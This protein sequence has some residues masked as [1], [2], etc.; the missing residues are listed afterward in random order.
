MGL[1]GPALGQ[2]DRDQPLQVSAASV[3]MDEKTGLTVYRGNV[4]LVQG[5]LRIEAD[6][7]E[8]RM[9]GQQLETVTAIGRPV[10]VRALLDN[11]K[12]ELKASAERLVYHANAR[13]LELSGNVSLN[14][15]GDQ[16]SAQTLRY[17]LDARHV[18]AHGSDAGDGR[19]H[20]V[21]Q[22]PPEKNPP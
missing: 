17:A 6:R 3:H 19:V 13:A 9:R 14:R 2:E 1:A 5:G 16:F 18:V 11:R 21:I 7:L 12:E 10:R 22:P 20:A 4:V 15:G 8:A